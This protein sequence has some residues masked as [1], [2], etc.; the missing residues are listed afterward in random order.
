[1]IDFFFIL[2]I[3]VGLLSLY[4]YTCL[5]CSTVNDLF[6]SLIDYKLT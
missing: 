5:Y 3:N 4:Q 1:M 6:N 2:Q